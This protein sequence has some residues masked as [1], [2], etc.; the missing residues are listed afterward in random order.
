MVRATIATFLYFRRMNNAICVEFYVNNRCLK[1]LEKENK[2]VKSLAMKDTLIT[3][4][5]MTQFGLAIATVTSI[6][7]QETPVDVVTNCSG[8]C[9]VSPVASIEGDVEFL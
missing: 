3:L 4:Y 2:S 7:Q 1:I 9:L 8:S 6:A 5:F